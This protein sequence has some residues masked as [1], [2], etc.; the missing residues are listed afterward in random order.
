M[1]RASEC[2]AFLSRVVK[3]E[4]RAS[5]SRNTEP[6]HERLV[7]VMPRTHADPLAVE[8]RRDVVGMDSLDVERDDTNSIVERPRSVHR[9]PRD[10]RQ[11]RQEVADEGELVL[12]DLF[13]PDG[14]E[15]VDRRAESDRIDVGARARLEL[16]RQ[17]VPLGHRD[18]YP[19]DHV[20]AVEERAH[21]LEERR[22]SPDNARARRRAT[23]RARVAPSRARRPRARAPGRTCPPAAGV[24]APPPPPARGAWPARATAGRPSRRA[25]VLPSLPSYTP[26]PEAPSSLLLCQG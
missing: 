5:R 7:A 12:V 6:G 23:R 8:D 14:P 15:V 1:H 18:R 17:L 11:A 9:H 4:A 16:P 13:D 22:T 19:G 24:R 10:L 26:Q 25:G 21:L 2:V 3:I 20:A